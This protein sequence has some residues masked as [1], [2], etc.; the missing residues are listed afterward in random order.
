MQTSISAI[1]DQK[2]TSFR[3]FNL[4]LRIFFKKKTTFCSVC[5]G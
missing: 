4:E 5:G 2:K 3:I 1:P